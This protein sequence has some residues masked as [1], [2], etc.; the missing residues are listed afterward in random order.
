MALSFGR[1]K[2]TV[3][4]DIGSG[5][6]KVAVIDHSKKTPELTRV[7][8]APLAQDAIVEGE[9][10]D[11]GVVADAIRSAMEKA[12]VTTKDVVIAVGGRDV[13][14]KKIQI[15]RVK[16]Q[17]VRELLR[18]EAEQHVPF[19]VESVELDHQ[20]LD[21][22]GTGPQ[23]DV[24]LVAA[25]RELIQAKQRVLEEAGLNAAI[26]DV[27]SF[28]LHNGFEVN[29]PDAMS[30]MVGL[31]NI[32]HDVT[33]INILENGV[34][35]LTR[36]VAV[37]TRRLREDM[38][39]ERGLSADESDKLLQ[40][41]DRSAHLDAIIETRGEEIAV[42]VDRALAFIQ[43]SNRSAELRQIYTCGGGARIPGLND[44]LGQRLRL[45]VQQANALANLTVRD[46]ALDA[47]VT[48]EVSPLL[49]L[50][51]GL[52]LRQVA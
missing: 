14:V 41:F 13:I 11:P 34:P 3:G 7:A 47:L 51:I 40:G 25:K 45:Q 10:M 48:D 12:G 8:I 39:R 43:Q 52:A 36:D 31:L 30:G 22:D 35:I 5:L 16:E 42:G 44:R 28:A 9:V 32:G 19:D 50:P 6:I 15:E 2:T 26:V 18:W 46:G 17:Q 24:L 21:P 38:M 23:M 49:M 1:K 20:T 37:G 4:L 29:H 33:N 27:E